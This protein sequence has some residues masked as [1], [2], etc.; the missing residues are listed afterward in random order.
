[1]ARDLRSRFTCKLRTKITMIRT[2][3]SKPQ[4]IILNVLCSQRTQAKG[5]IQGSAYLKCCTHRKRMNSITVVA[6]LV[7]ISAPHTVLPTYTQVSILQPFSGSGVIGRGVFRRRTK[8]TVGFP[9]VAVV[10]VE[11]L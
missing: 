5:N 9:S 7:P 3:K 10:F 1:M 8:C 2:R 6:G 11:G 4:F